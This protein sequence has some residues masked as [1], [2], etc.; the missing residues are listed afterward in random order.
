MDAEPTVRT[1]H[2]AEAPS[3][4]AS[5]TSGAPAEYDVVEARK[6]EH[7]RVTATQDVNT[8]TGAGWTDVYLQHEALPDWDLEDVNLSVEFLGRR[9]AAPLVIAGMTG[10]HSTALQINA[11]LARAAERHGL[12]MGVGSQRAA[13]RK[14]ELAYTYSVVRE[15]APSA[16]LIGNVGAAQLV[17]QRSGR[18]LRLEDAQTAVAMIRADAL[19]VH[20]NF[21]EECVQPE[22]DRRARGS[23]ESIRSLASSLGTPVLGKE[24]GAGISRSTAL[25]LKELGVS[26]LDIG[27]VGGT[28][29]AAIEGLRAEVQGD[30][31]GQRLGEVLR[32]WGVPTAVSIVG[33]RAAGLPMIATG[34]IRSGLD[35]AKAIALGATLVG[36]AKPFLQAA[37]EGDE[38]VDTFIEQTLHE[39]RSVVFLTGARSVTELHAKPRVVLGQ[40]HAWLEQLG[41]LG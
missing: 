40:T 2:D 16:F 33:A 25:R 19:A 17:E 13:L 31:Q 4:G 37:L 1:Q 3:V 18:A 8:R 26:A 36:V 23:G 20:L 15:H 28:S 14:P 5:A 22:G 30:R 12:A 35:A 9:L 32:D 27:G 7:L 38:A 21:L 29:F 41:Y 24:T 6:G 11:V 34:G 39:L 10:G